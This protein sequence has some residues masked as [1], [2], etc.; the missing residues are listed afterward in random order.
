MVRQL[1]GNQ[2]KSQYRYLVLRNQGK[3]GDY[4]KYY[5]EDSKSFNIY[6]NQIHDFTKQ[7]HNNYIKCYVNKVKPLLEYPYQYR[8]HMFQ[9]HQDYINN[10]REKQGSI[11][12][13]FV[14]N[15]INNMHPA[16][17]MY[18]LN[19]HLRKNIFSII[20]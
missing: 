1:R 6:R 5:P 9:L 20:E 10:L 16:K 13:S 17:L 19:Y 12:R 3:V 2:P 14:I 4:L 18:S 11:T 8:S 7:L 15:Y